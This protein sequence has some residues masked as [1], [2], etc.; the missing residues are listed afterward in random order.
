MGILSFV[1]VAAAGISQVVACDDPSD[2]QAW[3]FIGCRPSASEC[4]W[5]CPQKAFKA[6]LNED[7]CTFELE[8][9]ACYCPKITD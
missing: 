3:N 1:L 6:E 9:W 7:L 2:E 8:P 5:S 4:R